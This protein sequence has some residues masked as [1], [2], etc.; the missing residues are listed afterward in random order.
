MSGRY[1]LGPVVGLLALDAFPRAT[2][3]GRGGR[4]RGGRKRGTGR[5]AFVGGRYLAHRSFA[6]T[7]RGKGGR[8]VRRG[9]G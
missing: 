8:F 4:K 5:P 7:R 3:P 6:M 1:G 9:A 2:F